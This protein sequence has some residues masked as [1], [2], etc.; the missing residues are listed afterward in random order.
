MEFDH[1][2]SV[3]APIDAVWATITDIERVAPCVPNTR[4]TGRAGPDSFDVEIT[5]AIGLFEISAD[6]N[7][8]L[9]ER[10]DAA[11]REVL[12]VVATEP[13]GDNLAE[14][15][16]TIVLNENGTRTDGAVHSS[17]VPGGVATLINEETLDQVAGNALR[18]FAA[19]L[20]KLLQGGPA[21]A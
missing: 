13:D 8:T 11:R 21:A 15:T 19:N 2:F 18:T 9:T 3:S 10:D 20:E 1:A 17:V 16:V 6:G 12:R 7:I 5:A 4:V 14:A